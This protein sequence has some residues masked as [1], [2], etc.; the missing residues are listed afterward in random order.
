M[1]IRDS[2]CYDL[3]STFLVASVCLTSFLFFFA[4]VVEVSSPEFKDPNWRTT[5]WPQIKEEMRDSLSNPPF[6]IF[7]TLFWSVAIRPFTPSAAMYSSTAALPS[8]GRLAFEVAAVFWAADIFI[9]FEHQLMHTALFYKSVHK[10][11]HTYHIPTAFAG[12]ANH[13]LE[14]IFFTMAS[15]WVQLFVA[16]HPLSHGIFGVFG[17]TWTILS[18]DTR[19]YHDRGFHY[20]HH[21][22]P[23]RN[24]GAFTPIWDNMFGTRHVNP[25]QSYEEEVAAKKIVQAKL[26]QAQQKLKIK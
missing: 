9:Y 22:Y 8:W 21:F 5:R 14:A 25:T 15:L 13:P 1:C 19:S 3:V 24:F 6:A 16:I 23:N 4:G 26:H 2:D 20:Q 10:T 11:H 7:T 17:A 18:H 12:F